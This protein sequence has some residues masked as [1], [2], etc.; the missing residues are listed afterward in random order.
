MSLAMT[1]A[2]REEFLAGVHV[3]IVSVDDPGHGPLSV[4]VWYTYQPG[5]TV[6]VLTD[7]QSRKARHMR[8]AGRFTLCVQTESDPL[9][10]RERGGPDHLDQGHRQP[11]GTACA[12]PTAT[13]V[14]N[15]ATATWRPPP[16]TCR[17]ARSSACH[18]S[19]GSAPTSPGSSADD[20]RARCV[21][22]GRRS[23][24][25]SS[26][27]WWS[28]A[29]EGCV[30]VVVVRAAAAGASCVVVRGGAGVRGRVSDRRSGGAVVV[31]P[32]GRADV[33]VGDVTAPAAVGAVVADV[34]LAVT[35][36]GLPTGTRA[37][38]AGR[39][40]RAG[41]GRR[42]GRDP[43][44]QASPGPGSTS[45]PARWPTD[46]TRLRRRGGRRRGR[47]DVARH[48]G[49]QLGPGPAGSHHD[50]HGQQDGDPGQA[51]QHAAPVRAFRARLGPRAHGRLGP[52]VVELL[53]DQE[54]GQR[55]RRPQRRASASLSSMSH[56]FL[57]RRPARRSP[58]RRTRG[59]RL[60]ACRLAPDLG[61]SDLGLESAYLGRKSRVA[62]L[63][64]SMSGWGQN[65]KSTVTPVHRRDGQRRQDGHRHRLG[66]PRPRPRAPRRPAGCAR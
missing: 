55:V 65:P 58:Q 43:D 62:W 53:A 39:P 50:E 35:T 38:R 36:V 17:R 28:A 10:L 66:Q 60:E 57:E 31:G 19:A 61:P 27:W 20:G 12:W 16:T 1:R 41:L 23:G 5:G 32:G 54:I 7:G 46:G 15:W 48:L 51:G 3:G 11:R 9:L 47:G 24:R 14:R 64:K 4:P 22:K 29:A 26:S 63:A 34:R 18:P 21:L 33:G 6:D 52:R 49:R 45:T 13:S 30:V 44:E 56:P 2:E 59:A 42:R 40:G 37:A 25:R 8:A